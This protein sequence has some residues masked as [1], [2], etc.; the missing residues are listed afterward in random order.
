MMGYTSMSESPLDLENNNNNN[1]KYDKK[2]LNEK[3]STMQS[4][5]KGVLAQVRYMIKHFILSNEIAYIR[6]NF[7]YFL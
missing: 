2:I 7:T 1:V 6:D 4:N 3:E 5:S